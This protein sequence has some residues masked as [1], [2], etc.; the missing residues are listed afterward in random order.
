MVMDLSDTAVLYDSPTP[1][2][3]ELDNFM[4][5]YNML[6]LD[7]VQ[8]AFQV[9]CKDLLEILSQTIPCVGCRRR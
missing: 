2:G 5:K 1:K 6:T 8:N 4:L 9:T 7:D 3:K